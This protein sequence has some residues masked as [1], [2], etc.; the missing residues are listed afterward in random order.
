MSKVRRSITLTTEFLE[1]VEDWRSEQ[2][3]I[4]TVND[5]I[6]ELAVLGMSKK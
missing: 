2:K 4:P 5:A 6:V 1:K 3:P